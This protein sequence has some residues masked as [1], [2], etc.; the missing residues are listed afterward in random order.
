MLPPKGQFAVTPSHD[1]ATAGPSPTVVTTPEGF[2]ASWLGSALRAG[3]IACQVHRVVSVESI[4]TGQMAS[5]Y[6]ITLDATGDVPSSLVAK[7]SAPGATHLAANGYR[8][9]L[10]FYR[11]LARHTRGRIARCY[12]AAMEG[13]GTHFVLLLEDLAPAVQGDQ[14]AGCTAGE[15]R[16]ALVNLADLHGSLWEHPALDAFDET[17]TGADTTETF[18]GF[19]QWGTEQFIARYADRLATDDVDVLRGFSDRVRGYR[20]N[21]V[22]PRSIVHG[23]YRLDNLLYRRAG[24]ADECIVVDWQTA[25]VGAPGNDLA[26]C[27]STGLHPADRRAAE[28]DLVA[29]YGRRLRTCGVDRADQVL[30]ADYRHG[31]GHGVIITV[32]GAV[33]AVRTAR[34][35]DMFMAMASRVCTAI[36]DLDTLALY[37]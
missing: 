35:D 16:A 6:R 17:S 36:R 21:R 26:F 33:T 29:T 22:S 30:W 20:T 31:L 13:D 12:Y 19:M 28:R 34:G 18:V 5:C 25:A 2:T 8:N 1:Q 11:D 27:I 4:G 23:D 15:V 10:R 7:V 9:E 32:L 14:I 24:G 37:E 3:G